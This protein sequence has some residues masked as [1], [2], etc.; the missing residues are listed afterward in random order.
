MSL[1]SGNHYQGSRRLHWRET[2]RGWEVCLCFLLAIRTLS[3]GADRT[4]SSLDCNPWN[5][6]R[7]L[8]KHYRIAHTQPFDLPPP[9]YPARMTPLV[10]CYFW[11]SGLSYSLRQMGKLVYMEP[12][13]SQDAIQ[14]ML[15]LSY[16]ADVI[17]QQVFRP[18]IDQ[19]SHALLVHM[20]RCKL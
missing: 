10:E 6:L 8:R 18:R 19:R 1:R 2:D 14:D 9:E 12:E 5:L 3:D 16:M 17:P 7:V 4:L 13:E 15:N 20:R 11:L